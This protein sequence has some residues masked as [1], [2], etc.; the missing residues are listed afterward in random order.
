MGVFESMKVVLLQDVRGSG[1][2]GQIV[3]VS[4][5]YA[6]N[7]LLPKKL[8]KEA[9]SQSL[10]ELKGQQQA[11][12]Y[13]VEL[14]KAEAEKIY[15]IING[16]SLSISAASGEGQKMFGSVTA[17]D[18]CKEI[19]SKYDVN[20]NKKKVFLEQDIKAF[21]R[22]TCEIKLFSGIVANVYVNVVP[23]DK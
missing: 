21:G 1:K 5:G 2:K 17:K 15:G 10:N 8:A 23:I 14:E 6:K 7:Y 9:D 12:E 3:K 11:S 20:V 13:K 18:I 16:Q 22:Y 19:S 4:D